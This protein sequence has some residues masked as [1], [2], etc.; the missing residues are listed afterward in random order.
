MR[1]D[2][3]GYDTQP[4]ESLLALMEGVSLPVYTRDYEYKNTHATRAD[5]NPEL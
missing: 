4:T 5:R 3:N 2:I 1:R